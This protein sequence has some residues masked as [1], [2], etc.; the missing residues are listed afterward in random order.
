MIVCVCVRAWWGGIRF[1]SSTPVG[2]GYGEQPLE[3]VHV[4]VV[5]VPLQRNS[6]SRY[7]RRCELD[8][9][10]PDACDRQETSRDEVVIEYAGRLEYV[11]HT[12]AG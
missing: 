2:G 12:G 3:R 9:Q 11:E 7:P 1:D 5:R 8:G 4:C 10:R 6:R